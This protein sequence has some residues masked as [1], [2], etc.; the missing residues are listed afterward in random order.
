[1]DNL[2]VWFCDFDIFGILRS[3]ND[4][5]NWNFFYRGKE[6]VDFKKFPLKVAS[7]PAQNDVPIFL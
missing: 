6:M 7:C 4:S 1:M 3:W 5:S 2:S